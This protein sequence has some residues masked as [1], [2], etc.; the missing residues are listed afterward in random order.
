[1]ERDR[2]RKD[3]REGDDGEKETTM[4]PADIMASLPQTTFGIKGNTSES[5]FYSLL[6][7][8]LISCRAACVCVG[9]RVCVCVCVSEQ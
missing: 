4:R 6:H 7:Y 9:V 3:G 5:F 2:K 1:M 8:L